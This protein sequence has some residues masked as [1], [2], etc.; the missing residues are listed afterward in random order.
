MITFVESICSRTERPMVK[1]A[2]TLDLHASPRSYMNVSFRIL[3][4]REPKVER[5]VRL[6][7]S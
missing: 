1:K 3:I 5:L 2:L 7:S 4:L 6:E